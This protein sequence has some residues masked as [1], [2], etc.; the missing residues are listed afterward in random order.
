MDR[1]SPKPKLT[2]DVA[3]DEF[4]SEESTETTTVYDP[5]KTAEAYGHLIPKT[6]DDKKQEVID[7]ILEKKKNSLEIYEV[8]TSTEPVQYETSTE[9]EIVVDVTHKGTPKNEYEYEY[10]YGEETAEQQTAEES[11]EQPEY[12]YEYVYEYYYDDEDNATNSNSV[13]VTETTSLST[14]PSLATSSSTTSATDTTD[15]TSS[16]LSLLS[17]LNSERSSEPGSSTA[18]YCLSE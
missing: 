16:L 8:L 4:E 13:D 18:R 14:F 12:T 15:T 9:N 17:F 10:D 1:T 3:S 5:R 6:I 2:L 7:Q 11:V